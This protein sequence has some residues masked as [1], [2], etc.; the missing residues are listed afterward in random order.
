M[1]RCLIEFSAILC[2]RL[3]PEFIANAIGD[4]TNSATELRGVPLLECEVPIKVIIPTVTVRF[5][6]SRTDR[7][8]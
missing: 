3:E 8:K 5:E 4:S 7:D 2:C 1:N 6:S